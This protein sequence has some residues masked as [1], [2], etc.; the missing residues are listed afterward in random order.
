ML[1][2]ILAFA[3]NTLISVLP[4]VRL[5]LFQLDN[6]PPENN[7]ALVIYLGSLGLSFFLYINQKYILEPLS[8][9]L[10]KAYPTIKWL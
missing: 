9:K 4:A 5:G 10:I 8:T 1:V 2:T 7:V 6:M 3:Y